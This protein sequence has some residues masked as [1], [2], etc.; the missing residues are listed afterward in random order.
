MS[1][2]SPATIALVAAM[3]PLASLAGQQAM[4]TA[5]ARL[6]GEYTT[7]ARFLPASVA[8]RHSNSTSANT[9]AVAIPC[10]TTFVCR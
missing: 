6:V 5:Y 2:R 9:S 1:R 8:S 10:S 7:D 3:L 4:D